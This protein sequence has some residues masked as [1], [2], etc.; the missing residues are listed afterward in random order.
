MAQESTYPPKYLFIRQPRIY[1]RTSACCCRCCCSTT[2][3]G[4]CCSCTN[5]GCCSSHNG[6]GKRTCCQLCCTFSHV[7]CSTYTSHNLPCRPNCLHRCSASCDSTSCDS[8]SCGTNCRHS[9]C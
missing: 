5:G 4:A 7:L 9:T 2:S 6:S 3:G 8:A 1:G